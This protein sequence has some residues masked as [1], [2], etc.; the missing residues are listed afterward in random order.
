MYD[1][2]HSLKARLTAH[3]LYMSFIGEGGAG[4]RQ[5]HQGSGRR[6][7]SYYHDPRRHSRYAPHQGAREL[8]RARQRIIAHIDTGRT[9]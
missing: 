2:S 4:R 3:S 9:A 1:I 8:A 6:T 7:L 5:T